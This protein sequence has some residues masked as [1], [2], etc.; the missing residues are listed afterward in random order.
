MKFEGFQNPHNSKCDFNPQNLTHQFNRNGTT[1]TFEWECPNSN[2]AAQ[3]YW[4]C[5]SCKDN[6]SNGAVVEGEKYTLPIDPN[7]E[8]AYSVAC[9]EQSSNLQCSS[10]LESIKFNPKG[11]GKTRVQT[12]GLDYQQQ[13]RQQ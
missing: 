10:P 11:L 4:F 7:H 6:T 12:Q 9:F 13:L 1:V 2:G 8:Y 3:F 5:C